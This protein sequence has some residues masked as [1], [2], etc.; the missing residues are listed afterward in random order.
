M[1]P[2]LLI[3]S[4]GYV[5]A[6]AV[7]I[8]LLGFGPPLEAG[9]VTAT[10]TWDANTEP[11]IDG[12]ILSYGTQ[13]GQ[14]SNSIDVGNVTTWQVILSTGQRYYFAVRAYNSSGLFSPFSQE[15]FFDPPNAPPIL[16]NPGNRISAEGS[17]ASLQ[18]IAIDPD[19]TTLTYGATGLPGGL[20][21]NATTGLISGTLSYTSAGTH[22][23]T[24][25]ASDGTLSASQVFTWT[26]THTNAP[27]T[28]TNPG[29]RTNVKGAA[30]SLQLIASDVDGTSLTYSATN[31]PGGLSVD[32]TPAWA[33]TR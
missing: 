32:S 15:A 17:P 19:G 4:S 7:A 28:L 33:H 2:R 22:S 30:V 9:V 1:L 16:T 24:A 21:I 27:P 10:A 13:S 18:L 26:V 25:T 23:V 6:F 20:S 14:Y 31:L 11:D 3:V 8:C 29:S 12:Y 5:R